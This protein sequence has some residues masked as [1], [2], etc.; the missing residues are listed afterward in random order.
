MGRRVYRGV[1]GGVWEAVG[2]TG[3]KRGV[4][5]AGKAVSGQGGGKVYEYVGMVA[6]YV[7]VVLYGA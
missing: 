7:G 6:V 2:P 5:A 1:D 4:E 3:L